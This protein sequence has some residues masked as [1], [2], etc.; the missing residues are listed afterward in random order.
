V[1]LI[2]GA[3]HLF[4]AAAKDLVSAAKFVELKALPAMKKAQANA[5]VVE[6]ITGLVSPEAA[7]VERAAFA[8]LGVVIK[9]IEDAGTAAAANGLNVT[10]DAALVADVK[11]IIPAVKAQVPV[12][13]AA[14]AAA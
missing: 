5:A 3:E 13:G 7:N 2:S 8:A 12:A 14:A 10:L 6:A 4:A 1:V 9:A 11:S